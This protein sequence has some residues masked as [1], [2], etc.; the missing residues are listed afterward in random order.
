MKLKDIKAFLETLTEEQLEKDAVIMG[1]YDEGFSGGK[2]SVSALHEDW[3]Y[4]EEGN[5]PKSA[6]NDES[7]AEY[8]EEQEGR[9]VWPTGT[10]FFNLV[11]DLKGE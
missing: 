5:F 9:I 11:T 2:V 7:F 10:V 6:L 4:G 1:D 3:Y 8:M